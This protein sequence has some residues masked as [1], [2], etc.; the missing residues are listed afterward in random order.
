MF[1]NLGGVTLF[2]GHTSEYDATW[3]PFFY[4]AEAVLE[5]LRLVFYPL[6]N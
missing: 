4:R 2:W 6:F 3:N 1:H 5:W